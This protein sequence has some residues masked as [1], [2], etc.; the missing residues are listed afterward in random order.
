MHQPLERSL[1]A[2]DVIFTRRSVRA[3]TSK[4]IE[5]ATSRSLLDVAVHA[6]TALH[7][8]PW[9]FVVIQDK[10]TLAR[11]SARAKGFWAQEPGH[12]R[13]LHAAGD[14]AMAEAFAARFA[15]PDFDIFYDAGTLIVICVKPLGPFVAA[16]AWLAAENLMLAACA[17]GL[18]TC[19][20]GSAVPVLN[21]SDVKV[22]LGIPPEI[23]A[24]API[25]VGVPASRPAPA[26]VRRK[27]P[28]ILSWT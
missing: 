20:I 12:Y 2:L 22:E 5:P 25:I 13:D 3:Y 28:Q 19:C 7:A 14:L 6:P 4:Q 11:Y 23:E 21:S 18:G 10:A 17:L 8:E 26:A 24:I 27:D 1:S 15:S 16:D 9:A